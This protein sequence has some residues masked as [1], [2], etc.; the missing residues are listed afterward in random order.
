MGEEVKLQ[1][2][3]KI[4]RFQLIDVLG[5][6]A[7]SVVYKAFDPK[8]NRTIAIKLLR[9]ECA[10]DPEYRF[11]F[12]QEARAAGQ[13]IHPNIVTIFDVGEAPEGP[14]IA[15]EYLKGVTLQ[16]VFSPEKAVTLR[17]KIGYGIQLAD[18]LAYSHDS[19][20][21]H[22]DVKPSNIMLSA[23]G[24]SVRITD[25]G[26]AHIETPN[27]KQRTHM[28]VVMGTPQY[29]SPEQVEGQ[30]VD[31]R[32]DLFSLGV[33]LYQLVTGEKP[34]VAKTLT[35]LLMEIV[36]KEPE[37]IDRAARNIPESLQKVVEK[38]M[39]KRPEQRFQDGREVAD[40]LR[41]V[42][43]EMDEKEAHKG[44]AGIL[45]LRVKWTAVMAVVVSVAMLLGSYFVYQK[46]VEAMTELAVDSGG[47]LAEFIAIESAEAVLI[48]DW[49]AIETFVNEVKQRQQISYLNILDYKGVV[50]GST[51]IQHVGSVPADEPALSLMKNDGE[52]LYSEGIRNGVAVFDFRVPLLF[53]QKTIG[54]LQLGLSQAPLIAAAKLTLYTMLG[55]LAAVVL[56]VIVVA[57]LLAAGI[58]LPIKLLR[59]AVAN[60]TQGNY[61]YRIEQ[62]RNDELGQLFGEYNRMAEA[63]SNREELLS[64]A[65]AVSYDTQESGDA[66]DRVAEDAVL[67]HINDPSDAIAGQEVNWSLG[68]DNADLDLLADEPTMII[69]PIKKK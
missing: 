37:P 38:L 28:G 47:S 33:I 18:A 17:E 1:M 30:P 22:R 7:M 13:L 60:V 45:P 69:R 8:I 61:N 6:G 54:S 59:R 16:S 46:Q 23:D 29:M 15:M 50:R 49:I 26:I 25:F 68:S 10:A 58:T 42:V 20:V 67:T 52:V 11:R 53:Q 27:R 57:Y 48:Q 2:P 36:Q 65:A 62:N 34:F 31:G 63:L 4:G 41:H 3:E 5:E 64:A 55:L 35:T 43:N 51:S 14:Y 24:Q 39:R 32:S 44:E 9:G 12:L 56:T 66:G 40:A 21:V 19:S